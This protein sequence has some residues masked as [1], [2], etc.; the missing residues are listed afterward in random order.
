MLRCGRL[1]GPEWRE[2]NMLTKT[3]FIAM[4]EDEIIFVE[5]QIEVLMNRR[6][7]LNDMLNEDLKNE[8]A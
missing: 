5:D 3:D 8:K 1:N 7:E 4:L 2:E 6:E